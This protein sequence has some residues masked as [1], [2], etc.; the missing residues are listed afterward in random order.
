MEDPDLVDHDIYDEV[1][2]LERWQDTLSELIASN[3]ITQEE[4]DDELLKT[5][6]YIDIRTKNYILEDE[7]AELLTKLRK[8]KTSLSENYKMGIINETEFNK[9]FMDILRKEY[10]VLKNAETEEQGNNENE[11]IDAPLSEKLKKLHLKEVSYNKKI[12]LKNGIQYPK[13]PTGIKGEEVDIYYDK[14][15]SNDPPPENPAIEE[16]LKKLRETKKLIDYHTSSF[17]VTKLVYDSETGKQNYKFK[18]IAPMSKA[19]SD[20]KILSKRA[21]LLTPQEQAYS[22]RLL[23]MKQNLRKIPREDLL[24]CIGARTFKFMSYIERLRENKQFVFK[25]RENP[26][27]YEVLKKILGEENEK[28]YKVNSDFIFKNYTYSLP[29]IDTSEPTEYL[30]K[31]QISYLA[32]KKGANKKE[33]LGTDLSNYITVKPM[34]DPLYLQIKETKGDKTETGEVWELRTSLPGSTKKELIKRYI[35]FEDYLY[36]LK[37][38]LIQNSKKISGTSRD[39]LNDRIRKISYYLTHGED[40]ENT[41]PSGQI[42]ID[43]L[44]KNREEIQTLRRE[45][46]Y[47]IMNYITTYYPGAQ[48]LAENTEKDIFNYS[49]ANYKFNIEKVIFIFKN[50]SEK[51]QDYVEGDET[52]LN[53]LTYE[54]PNVL[55]E[56]DIDTSDKEGTIELL[57]NWKP[58]TE[59]YDYYY[60]ELEELNHSF[61]K[62]K[63]KHLE[64]SSL[65]IQEIMSQHAEK[66]QWEKSL[67]KFSSLEVPEGNIAINYKLRFLLKERNRL[68]SRRIYKVARVSERINN[69]KRLTIVFKNCRVP[70]PENYAI[71]T[72]QIIVSL[73]KTPEEYNYYYDLI[74][75]QYKKLCSFFT[76]VNLKCVLDSDGNVKC[77]LEFEPKILV[78]TITEFLITEGDF[79]TADINRLRQFTENMDSQTLKD[80]IYSLRGDALNVYTETLSNNKTFEKAIKVL[81]SAAREEKYKRLVE[82]ANN[83][84]KPPIVSSE[85]PIVKMVGFEYTKDHIQIEDNYIYGGYYPL[86]Y[87]YNENGEIIKEN[88]TRAELEQL[89]ILF[90]VTIVDDSFELYQNIMNFISEYNN[91]KVKVERLNYSPVEYNQYYEYLKTDIKT[92]NYTFRPRLGVPEPGEVYSVTK[93]P[94]RKYGVPFDFNKDSI[95]VYSSELKQ[96]VDDSFIIIE[97]PCIFFDTSPQNKL[98]S[99]SYILVEYRDS[100]GKPKLFREGVSSKKIM[101]RKL[102]S[103]NTCSR[104]VNKESC[105]NPNSFS[106]EIDKM[107]FKCKWLEERCKGVVFEDQ[108]IKSF[109]INN[110]EFKT[111]SNKNLFDVAVKIAI[112]YVE[113][114]VKENN[115]TREEI[116]ILSK[117]QKIRLYNYYLKLLESDKP[118]I[119][120]KEEIRD[121]FY[122]IVD[123]YDFLKKPK[124]NV[125]KKEKLDTDYM[126]Y[127]V[128]D[129]KPMQMKLPLKRIILEKEYRINSLTIIP[130]SF[131]EDN[132]VNCEVADTGE[133]VTLEKEEFRNTSSEIIMKTVPTFCYIHKD[134]YKFLK[135]LPGYFWYLLKDEYKLEDGELKFRK[136]KEIKTFIPTNFIQPSE[137][138]NGRPL[139]TKEDIFS[140]IS[141][142]AFSEFET[143]DEIIYNLVAKINI[144]EDAILF[145]IKNR[146]DV[147]KM[148]ETIIGNITLPMVLEEYEKI[149]PKKFMSLT[150]LTDIIQKA[151]AERDR[152]KL[153]EYYTR[154]KKAKIDQEL[155]MEAKKLI[156]D[157]K[158]PV[159]PEP[160]PIQT[161]QSV[162][163]QVTKQPI[164]KSIYTTKRRR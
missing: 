136:I 95:P 10:S 60:S 2:N 37:D 132:T 123:D 40:L 45:G 104:F 106:L 25:F 52:I 162:E 75:D 157:I 94:E 48:I 43:K 46:L 80:Y 50:F 61:M 23:N 42:P 66:L 89:A 62:F 76:K 147:V 131:N 32:F 74:S 116:A 161:G 8:Y 26:E 126:S 140:A 14:K 100:R 163:Q 159:E 3:D 39:I 54:T 127:T 151:I 164:T 28:Y 115:S 156:K 155:L 34:D 130:K 119:E 91:K 9:E 138:I 18:K 11:D 44:F 102:D 17:E 72:E 137:E 152:S 5:R 15:M 73:S 145:A 58:N 87:H 7:E 149:N 56:D 12:A 96:L 29:D 4:Y 31:G 86:F 90:N 59:E 107:K 20:I 150:E 111:E 109:D 160:V 21:N 135:D 133:N 53:L 148:T 110:V 49:S 108:E 98:I 144:Q 129:I 143:S 101:K 30:Q 47:K 120:P 141:K 70:E 41:K 124:Q 71:L 93:D 134:N 92:I 158:D 78:P 113:S 19:V 64:L 55:P 103:L 22:D 112:D 88:Y 69:Q 38:V 68:P 36:D 63:N 84:Y 81:K 139:I 83:I 51:L 154:A 24:K 99:D 33:E 1:A 57:L 6:Y 121:N 77:I 114:I 67:R 105:D 85:K 122:S 13:L 97:G 146:V 65:K 16:Y 82:I 125:I 117:E 153:I 118:K 142:T 27:N 128:H 79:Q 35:D